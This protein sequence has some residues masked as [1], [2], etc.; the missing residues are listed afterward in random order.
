[1]VF[2]DTNVIAVLNRDRNLTMEER[3]TLLVEF[4][5][6]SDEGIRAEMAYIEE[7]CTSAPRR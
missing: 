5:G 7:I 4:D 3:P 6:F 1:M 2:I